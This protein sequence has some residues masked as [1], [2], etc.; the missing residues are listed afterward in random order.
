MMARILSI[1]IDPITCTCS[2]GC[3]VQCPEILDG[4]T[5]N[6]IPRIREGAERYFETHVEQI[7]MAAWACPVDAVKLEIEG[8]LPC[9]EIGS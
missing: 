7:K 2:Q 1:Y 9:G 3:V 4:N 6:H 8:D 5:E